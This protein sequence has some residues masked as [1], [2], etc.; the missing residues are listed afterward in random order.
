MAGED[1]VMGGTE[2]LAGEVGAP[3]GVSSGEETL[4]SSG[5]RRVV[6]SGGATPEQ[7]SYS[8]NSSRGVCFCSVTTRREILPNE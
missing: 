2:A 6:S 5:A 1:D 8:T 7:S 4:N 3:R